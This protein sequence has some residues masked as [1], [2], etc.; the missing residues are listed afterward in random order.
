MRNTQTRHVGQMRSFCDVKADGTYSNHYA[1]KSRIM[2]IFRT[3][4]YNLHGH[5]VAYCG[6]DIEFFKHSWSGIH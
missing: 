3:E 2:S 4:I 6:F 1:L 5:T